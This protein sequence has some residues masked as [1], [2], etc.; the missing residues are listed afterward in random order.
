MDEYQNKLVVGTTKVYLEASDCTQRECTLGN[1]IT[2][3]MLFYRM[4]Y[5]NQ[6]FV[7]SMASKRGSDVFGQRADDKRDVIALFNS[8]LIGQ[9]V[10]EPDVGP[11]RQYFI[12]K[13]SLD[14]VFKRGNPKINMFIMSGKT[15]RQILEDQTQRKDLVQVS[16][17]KVN[18]DLSKDT[19]DKINAISVKCG[20]C[21]DEHYSPLDDSKLYEVLL[22]Q[23]IGVE[24]SDRDLLVSHDLS[25]VDIL[26]HYI[27]HN[28]PINA[29]VED[30]ITL[31]NGNVLNG[32]YG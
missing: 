9:S 6:T 7:N 19:N 2:D 32:N 18:Y 12:T 5:I 1:L 22:P 30:R 24:E 31:R 13:I 26:Q 4:H 21:P 29:T 3:A 14:K 25:V 27:K 17:I 16:G 28:S 8:E 20:H 10:G 11:D 23:S 15:V